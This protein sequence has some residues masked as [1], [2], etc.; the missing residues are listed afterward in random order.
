[1]Q[2]TRERDPPVRVAMRR[3]EFVCIGVFYYNLQWPWAYIYTQGLPRVRV[4][5]NKSDLILSTVWEHLP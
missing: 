5:D 4:R 1:M 3:K 2:L